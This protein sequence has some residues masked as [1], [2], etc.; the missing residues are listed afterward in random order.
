MRKTERVG[1]PSK[2][3]DE[4]RGS[5]GELSDARPWSQSVSQG[6]T[7]EGDGEKASW[8]LLISVTR[9][10]GEYLAMTDSVRRIGKVRE[11]GRREGGGRQGGKCQTY[12]PDSQCLRTPP[13]PLY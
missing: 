8:H 7:G 9:D 1:S 3:R 2:V 5:E 13:P 4:V 11:G 12:P 6:E 10:G